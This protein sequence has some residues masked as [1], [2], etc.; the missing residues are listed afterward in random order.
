VTLLVAPKQGERFLPKEVSVFYMTSKRFFLTTQAGLSFLKK[1]KKIK[2]KLSK[3]QEKNKKT[4]NRKENKR[5]K[6][7]F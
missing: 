1:N 4:K 7:V 3:K 6:V 5:K 2:E